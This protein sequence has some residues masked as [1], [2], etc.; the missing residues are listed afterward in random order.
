MGENWLHNV[1]EKAGLS[2]WRIDNRSK[3][4]TKEQT[5]TRAVLKSDDCY[6]LLYTKIDICGG[7]S[8][9]SV[10]LWVGK[11]TQVEDFANEKVDDLVASIGECSRTR[12]SQENESK[13]FHGYF[14]QG[15]QYVEPLSL[16]KQINLRDGDYPTRLY[17]LK[18]RRN[19]RLSLVE[20]S[21]NALNSGDV[22][23]L[24]DDSTIYQ[25][26]GKAA[27]RMEKGKALDLTTRLRDERMNRLKAEIVVMKEGMESEEFWKILGG[28]GVVAPAG[29]D[30]EEWE[31]LA[32]KDHKLYRVE[33]MPPAPL[34][35]H[36]VDTE[37]HHFHRKHL[38]ND[39]SHI[40]D[41]GSQLF[42][43][44]GRGS[45]PEVKV[46]MPNRARQFLKEQ[47]RPETIPVTV[48]PMG[49]EPALFKTHFLGSFTEYIDTQ[50]AF[51]GRI[52]VSNKTAGTLR[53]EKV[54]VDALLHPEKYAIARE[55]FA[56]YIPS[57]QQEGEV[58]LH[59]EFKVF[60]VDKKQLHDLPLEEYGI[61]YSGQAYVVQ[62]T[63]RPEGGTRKFVVY[64]WHGRNASVQDKGSASLLA[65]TLSSKFGRGCTLCRVVQNKEP[66]HFLSHF[67]G[68]MCVRTG[69][70]D[71]WLTT[72]A[73]KPKL[74][75]IRGD[76]ELTATASQV[77]AIAASLN[78]ADVYVL[79]TAQKIFIWQGKGSNEFERKSATVLCDR[80]QE[81]VGSKEKVV[82][83]E[84]A[85]P[86]EFWKELGGKAAYS[87]EPHRQSRDL[88]V[89][90]FQCSART[91]VFKVIE[92]LNFCQDDLDDDDVMLLDTYREVYIWIGTKANKKEKEKAMTRDVA[93]EYIELADDGRD[94]DSPIYS[95]DAGQEP[96]QFT[97]YF[98]G[99][100]S[101]QARTGEDLYSR[102]LAQ[103]HN[104]GGKLLGPQLTAQR[105]PRIE[106]MGPTAEEKA[107]GTISAD[108]M[109]KKL[110][111]DGLIVDFDRLKVKPTPEGVN[112][113]NLEAYLSDEQFAT[114]IKLTR[115]E[116]Y[117]LPQWKQLRHKKAVGLF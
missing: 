54:N 82:I 8:T 101:K 79:E 88:K 56:E 12:E 77:E 116:F 38:D 13:E 112:G 51:E 30:D 60:Y 50:E 46:E 103:V 17:K 86:E 10:F 100:N 107:E 24:D 20:I 42:I 78:S 26:N 22:F 61:F 53:Q 93:Q 31:N 73:D 109:T 75:Q 87:N 95:I 72:T 32:I 92:I 16:K 9:Y 43:W 83:D 2:I 44:N 80:V 57:A 14:K 68:Y 15:I 6:V 65:Q 81:Q 49:V 11:T 85:E 90:L 41:T 59:K 27:S 115:A 97:S 64:H 5:S 52:K 4:L 39:F 76:T 67:Q 40:F 66:E 47:G 70:R 108:D 58:V 104:E 48:C 71:T 25:W 96:I 28:K 45:P 62:Y 106:S 84:E 69:K 99:W 89:R 102:K 33:G 113:A 35:L 19:I 111:P 29:N 34:T 1:G 114:F 94:K 18:G 74:Y 3:Q 55:E 117:A 91:G 21:P 7:P 105:R 37:G 23:I 36:P 110:N 63:V 98:K